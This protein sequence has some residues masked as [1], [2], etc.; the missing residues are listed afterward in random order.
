MGGGW[1]VWTLGSFWWRDDDCPNQPLNWF[2]LFF[3]NGFPLWI[4]FCTN[5]TRP[6]WYSAARQGAWWGKCPPRGKKRI[7]QITWPGEKIL[8]QF[9]PSGE[10]LG[11]NRGCASASASIYAYGFLYYF[12]QQRSYIKIP[13][14]IM[15]H[16]HIWVKIMP[17]GS[18]A[19]KHEIHQVGTGNI[20]YRETPSK[21]TL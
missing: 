18:C 14:V 10:V 11:Q 20:A 17:T 1:V 4:C 16:P 19:R 7:T 21:L 12:I 2:P 15:Q 13:E 6:W 9:L 3:F 8:T 5:Q